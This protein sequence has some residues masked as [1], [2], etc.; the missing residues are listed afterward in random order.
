MKVRLFSR[1]SGLTSL[2]PSQKMLDNAATRHR[3]FVPFL[4]AVTGLGGL[5]LIYSAFRLDHTQFNINFFILLGMALV[6]GSRIIVP[7]PRFSSQISVSDTFVFLILW[8]Y[9]G[10]VALIVASLDAIFSTLR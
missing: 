2:Q 3:L 1:E 4:W 6:L 8:L 10:E 9:G 5:A 7:I